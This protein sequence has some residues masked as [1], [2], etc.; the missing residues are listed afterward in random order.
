MR[1]PGPRRA[2]ADQVVAG[3]RK[4][5]SRQHLHLRCTGVRGG[6]REAGHPQPDPLTRFSLNADCFNG[7][8]TC[9][10]VALNTECT[11]F[12]R[13]SMVFSWRRIAQAAGLTVT[14]DSKDL[15]LEGH[16]DMIRRELP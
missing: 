6:A 7:G 9:S 13:P 5:F 11:L 16:T 2:G 14:T 12:R 4:L 3:D 8:S 15:I 1:A 10:A